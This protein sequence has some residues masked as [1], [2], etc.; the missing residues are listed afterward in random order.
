MSVKA[1]MRSA[2]RWLA[3]GVGLAAGAYATYVGVAWHRYGHVPNEASPEEQDEL[4]DRFMPKYEVVERHQ[5]H[6]AAPADITFAA[7]CEMDLMQSPIIRAIF[8][9]RELVLGSEPDTAAHPRGVLAFTKSLGWNVLM[10]APGREIVMGTVTQPWNPNVVFRR[11]TP[12]QFVAFNESDYVKIAWTLRA[13]AT[14]PNESIF[15]HET[16]VQTTDAIA[17][18]KFRRYWAFFSPGINLIRWLILEPLRRDAEH[19][20]GARPALTLVPEASHAG[21]RQ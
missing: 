17:R 8:R 14:A 18:I 16:R 1:H 15:R 2:A 10:E 4:L 19:R 3:A 12:D 13:D 5:I 6:I 11:L 21:D 7:A 9:T 20:A